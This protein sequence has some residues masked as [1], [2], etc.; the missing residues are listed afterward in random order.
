MCLNRL[1]RILKDEG[2]KSYVARRYEDDND[3]RVELCKSILNLAS[4]TAEI[5]DEATLCCDEAKFH[6]RA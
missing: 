2:F 6:L 4:E 5:F 3:R 1:Y